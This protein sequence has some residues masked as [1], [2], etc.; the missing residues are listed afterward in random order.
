MNKHMDIKRT[1]LWVVFSL[2]ILLLWD[3][4]M[5][6]T[7]KPSMFF[8]SAN[9]QAKPA[10]GAAPAAPAAN[11]Q[12]PQASATPAAAGAAAV[13][14]APAAAPVQGERVTITTDVLKAEIDS[15]GGE[16]Q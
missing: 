6:Y 13:P 1:V 7:G 5:R 3:N 8:P 11:G 9:Q 4:W 14:G 2:S 12:V 10:A 16:L 15:I